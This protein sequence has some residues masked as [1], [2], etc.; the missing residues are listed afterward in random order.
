[1]VS[2]ARILVR[3]S[4]FA[5]LVAASLLTASGSAR[6]Q[7]VA[8]ERALLN[9]SPERRAADAARVL[10]GSA[11][12]GRGPIDGESALLNRRAVTE[13]PSEPSVR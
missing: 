10:S 4:L 11:A 9:Q 7:P 13:A 8:P 1:M 12:E 3:K 2:K 6:A 5:S